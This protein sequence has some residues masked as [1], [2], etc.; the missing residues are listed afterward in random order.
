MILLYVFIFY[1]IMHAFMSQYVWGGQRTSRVVTSLF[2]PYRSQQSHLGHQSRQHTEP[3]HWPLTGIL[4]SFYI[5]SLRVCLN[6]IWCQ[7]HSRRWQGGKKLRHVIWSRCNSFHLCNTNN[8]SPD[9]DVRVP[10]EVQK[11][12][13]SSH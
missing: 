7:L 4:I 10:A 1:V 12:K 5:E 3:S 2:L 8:K 11:S 13:A 6:K 9:A